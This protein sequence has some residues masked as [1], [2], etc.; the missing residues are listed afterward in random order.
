MESVAERRRGPEPKPGTETEA[1]RLSLRLD[2]TYKGG[3]TWLGKKRENGELDSV[4]EL[5]R[6]PELKPAG[7]RQR[8]RPRPRD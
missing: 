2:E 7:Q 3:R 8:R 4:A 5:R 6:G 1:E